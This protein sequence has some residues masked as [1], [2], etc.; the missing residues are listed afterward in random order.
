[1][2]LDGQEKNAIQNF[3]INNEELLKTIWEHK[4]S[5]KREERKREGFFLVWN[6][7]C[8]KHKIIKFNGVSIQQGFSKK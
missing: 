2:H 8:H 6:H 5:R 3:D 4:K 1:M 7:Y